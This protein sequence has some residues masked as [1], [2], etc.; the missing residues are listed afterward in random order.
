[1]IDPCIW[2]D[3]LLVGNLIIDGEHKFICELVVSFNTK[4]IDSTISYREALELAHNVVYHIYSHCAREEILMSLHN[5]SL[6]DINLHRRIHAEDR[7]KLSNF[8]DKIRDQSATNINQA[9]SQLIEQLYIL[10]IEHIKTIDVPLL[11]K[12]LSVSSMIS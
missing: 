1:M 8:L 5:A 6:E 10:V 9:C 2:G 4:L 11:K 3:D 7:V 12:C